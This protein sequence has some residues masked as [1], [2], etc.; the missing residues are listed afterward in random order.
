MSAQALNDK[1]EDLDGICVGLV[2]LVS[3]LT[4]SLL[5]CARGGSGSRAGSVGLVSP[6][7]GSLKR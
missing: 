4:E 5:I 2:A 1:E 3:P 6:A 7:P